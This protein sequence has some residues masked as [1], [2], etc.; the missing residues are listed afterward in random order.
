MPRARPGSEKELQI[1]PGVGPSIAHDLAELGVRRVADL[2]GRKPE[3]LYQQ[4]CT[5]RGV[6]QDRCVLYVFRC[7]VY[8]ASHRVHEPELLQWWNWSDAKLAARAV[9]GR[10]RAGAAP[11][12][13]VA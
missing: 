11:R 4:L 5:A 1:I 2:R 6:H 3:R 12:T 7:A 8:F 10:R 9:R 13:R